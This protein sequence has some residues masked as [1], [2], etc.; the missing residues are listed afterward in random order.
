MILFKINYKEDE[1]N[2]I[3]STSEHDEYFE[4]L[5]LEQITEVREKR[6]PREAICSEAFGS[7]NIQQP[8]LIPEINEKTFEQRERIRAKLNQSFIFSSL[9]LN[10]KEI[11]IDA[12]KEQKYKYFL[13]NIT[14]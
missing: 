4:D 14:L 3:E 11:I 10:Q 6:G 1:K 12:M 2:D 9:D 7:W 5:T 13:Y 8:L